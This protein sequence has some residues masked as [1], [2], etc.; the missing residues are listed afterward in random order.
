MLGQ[1]PL[2]TR[3]APHAKARCVPG[4]SVGNCACNVHTVVRTDINVSAP[5]PSHQPAYET[6]SS[7]SGITHSSASDAHNEVVK[8]TGPQPSSSLQHDQDALLEPHQLTARITGAQSLA[9]LN[10][11]VGPSVAQL[12]AIHIAAAIVKAAKLYA[13]ASELDPSSAE[14]RLQ[15]GASTSQC[16]TQNVYTSRQNVPGPG[17]VPAQGILYSA[18][19]FHNHLQNSYDTPFSSLPHS[20]CSAQQMVEVLGDRFLQLAGSGQY[21]LARHHANITWALGK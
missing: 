5:Y 10:D 21:P 11:L 8:S 19:D 1:V 12:N 7:A 3:R 2:T 17:H 15:P 16:G 4:P 9:E 18:R 20:N 6:S 13:T 14:S